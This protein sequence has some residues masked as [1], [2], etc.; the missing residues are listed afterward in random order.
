MRKRAYGSTGIELSAIGFGGILVTDEEPAAAS[1]LVGKAIDRGIDYFDV[2]PSYGNAQER[3]G[4][5]LAPYRQDVFLACK[6]GE[7]RAEGAEKELQE[8]LRLLQT[9]YFDLYQFHG[10]TST[11]EVDTILGP[12]GAVETFEKARDKG[13]VRH[14]GF[15]AHSE[16]AAVRLLD[17]FPFDSVLFPLNW[18]TWYKSGFGPKLVEKAQAKGAAILALKALARRTWR[19]NEQPEGS[20]SWYHPAETY[21]EAARGVRFTLSLPVTAAVSP[22]HEHLFDWACDAADRFTE[23]TE[24]TSAAI[25]ATLA[26]QPGARFHSYDEFSMALEAARS[27]LL[28]E[29]YNSVEEE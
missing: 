10:V 13:L 15:S 14:L 5:A 8:S 11:D 26:K 3:L 24:A 7:R 2:A 12:G 16:E 27:H 22:G 23:I 29:R 19:E 9:D 6:T 1:R 17:A 20:K 25:L 18:V 21:E 4:P 28:V